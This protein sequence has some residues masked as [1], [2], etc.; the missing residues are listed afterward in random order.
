[1]YR[2]ATSVK[3]EWTKVFETWLLALRDEVAKAGI[4]ARITRLRYGNP[5]DAHSV[6]GKVKELKR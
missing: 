6:G 4:V 5:G 3:V 1:M 2:I